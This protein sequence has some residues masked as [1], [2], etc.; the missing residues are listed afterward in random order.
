MTKLE[1]SSDYQPLS[2]EANFGPPIELEVKGGVHIAPEVI[3]RN[4]ST[5]FMTRWP[6]GLPR[7]AD[8][9][10]TLRFPH[11]LM[12]FGETIDEVTSRLVGDQLGMRVVAVRTLM[13][14][15]YVDDMQHWHIE[16]ILLANVEGES[17]VPDSASEII[18]FKLDSVP[19]MTFWSKEDFQTTLQKHAPDIYQTL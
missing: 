4:G 3:A 13:I 14:D 7:H 15:S 9:P 5:F 19:D 17:V 8:P 1:K 10:N 12:M 16:P 6:S 11:G 2:G 18:E